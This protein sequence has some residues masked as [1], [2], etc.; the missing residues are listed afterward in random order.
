MHQS[1]Q[2]D[3]IE[4]LHWLMTQ[5]AWMRAHIANTGQYSDF[6]RDVQLAWDVAYKAT[7]FR[8]EMIGRQVRCALLQTSINSLSSNIRPATLMLGLQ[9]GLWDEKTALSYASQVAHGMTKVTMLTK[10][11]AFL[12]EQHKDELAQEIFLD[13]L[14]TMREID[15]P[16]DFVQ[17]L[18]TVAQYLPPALISDALGMAQEIPQRED[19]ARV[20]SALAPYLSSDLMEEALEVIREIG[21]SDGRAIALLGLAPY[22]PLQAP[23]LLSQMLQMVQDLYGGANQADVLI[24]LAAHVPSHARA[25][26]LNIAQTIYD[27]CYRAAVLLAFHLYEDPE[28]RL[29]VARNALLVAQNDHDIEDRAKGIA[30]LAPNLPEELIPEALAIVRTIGS[31]ATEA[32]V[33]LA[34]RLP[35]ELQAE[36]I[37]E[38]QKWNIFFFIN[39]S[40][41]LVALISYLSPHLFSTMLEAAQSIIQ[42]V[43]ASEKMAH[44]YPEDLVPRVLVALFPR[45][46]RKLISD[47][48]AIVED[49]QAERSRGYALAQ[50]APY[51]PEELVPKALELVRRL[52]AVYRAAA[53]TAFAEHGFPVL[54]DEALRSAQHVQEADESTEILPLLLTAGASVFPPEMRS[55]VIDEALKIAREIDNVRHRTEAFLAL[56][57]FLPPERCSPVIQE[58]LGTAYTIQ[59]SKE[60]FPILS[61]LLTLLP[62]EQWSDVVDKTLKAVQKDFS[63][64]KQDRAIAHVTAL[65]GL[66]PFLSQ[67]QREEAVIAARKLRHPKVRSLSLAAL[68]SHFPSAQCSLL[69]SEALKA[70]WRIRDEERGDRF[71][72]LAVIA[73]HLPT[74]QRRDVLAEALTAAKKVAAIY[75]LELEPILAGLFAELPSDLLPSAV[76]LARQI[77]SPQ[78]LIALIPCVPAEEQSNLLD[79]ALTAIRQVASGIHRAHLL[80]KLMPYVVPDRQLSIL[81]E[82]LHAMQQLDLPV[83]WSNFSQVLWSLASWWAQLPRSQAYALWVKESLWGKQSVLHAYAQYRR[84]YFLAALFG[85]F[86]VIV[87]LGDQAALTESMNA[88]LE[89]CCHWPWSYR[90][91]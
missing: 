27:P 13:T 60:Q 53:L 17:A 15:H 74:H 10:I 41:V 61:Q 70:A 91:V 44:I 51:L 73:M 67:E 87:A 2:T 24:A 7:P 72:A 26:V 68:A 84:S 9:T 89:I 25:E 5:P 35:D 64:D 59:E 3:E 88:V 20:L 66:A 34:P 85:L 31:R 69:L 83:N 16:A 58:A 36:V 47:A 21:A 54:L 65:S 42:E 11:G 50:I 79:D 46:P 18:V 23:H 56:A 38:V 32:L 76:T 43:Y 33:A 81:E 4:D 80:A 39:R 52:K 14:I 82:A 19:R 30:L 57:P 37:A 28:K 6:L 75:R 22:L 86:P 29:A 55:S 90:R 40:E 45:L 49:I 78:A 8:S 1:A 48:L 63:K 12:R 62:P 77:G 71:E